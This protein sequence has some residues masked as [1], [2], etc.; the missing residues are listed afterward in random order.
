MN[1]RNVSERLADMDYRSDR[2]HFK[3]H[4]DLWCR[5]N[6]NPDH[7]E[8]LDNVGYFVKNDRLPTFNQLQYFVR[9]SIIL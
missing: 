2:F 3:N 1:R 9:L 5:A 4:V 7:S 6:C 8:T